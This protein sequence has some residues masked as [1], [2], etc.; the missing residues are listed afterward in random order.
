M[1]N[2]FN[3]D[4]NGRKHPNYRVE[5]LAKGGAPSVSCPAIF[6][7]DKEAI[8]AAMKESPSWIALG[9]NTIVVEKYRRSGLTEIFRT[10]A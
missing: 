4:F 6:K 7:T 1:A 10:V 5:Y 3:F 8:A 2:S 9:M